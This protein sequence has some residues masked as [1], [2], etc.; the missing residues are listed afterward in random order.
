MI[1]AD[2]IAAKRTRLAVVETELARLRN[3]YDLAMSAFKFDEARELH[4]RIETGENERRMLAEGLPPQ[5]PVTAT[6]AMRRR[7]SPLRRRSRR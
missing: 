3:Q 5:P 6:P 4:A 2:D 1:S 7:P